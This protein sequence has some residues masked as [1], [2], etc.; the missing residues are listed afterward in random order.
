MLAS[1]ISRALWVSGG[2]SLPVQVAVVLCA[3]VMAGSAGFAQAPP[4][5]STDD[6]SQ[7][8]EL[9]RAQVCFSQAGTYGNVTVTTSGAGCGSDID[10]GGITGMWIGDGAASE[11]CTFSFDHPVDGAS[12]MVLLTAHSCPTA[13]EKVRF[14]LNGADYNVQPAD[15]DDSSPP[16]GDEPVTIL[17]SGEVEGAPVG[18]GDGRATVLFNSGPYA[19]TS[20]EIEH[21][22]TLGDAGGSVYQ[23]CIDDTTTPVDLVTFTVE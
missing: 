6:S 22:H 12:A 17:A 4:V 19:T 16:G 20:I 23:I 14:R 5:P 8:V 7:R 21:T 18:G 10:W 11:T 1:G 2:P 13:C 3:V 9:P 15:L